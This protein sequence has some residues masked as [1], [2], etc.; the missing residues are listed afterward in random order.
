MCKVFV[1]VTFRKLVDGEGIKMSVCRNP[2][3]NSAIV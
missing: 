1:T 2:T 3:V